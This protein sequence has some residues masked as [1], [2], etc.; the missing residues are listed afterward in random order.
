M[1]WQIDLSGKYGIVTG[2]GSGIGKATA[3]HLSSMGA[4]VALVDIVAGGLDATA[5][6]IQSAGEASPLLI[7]ADAAD[8]NQV[9]R[10]VAQCLAEFGAIDFLVNGHGILRRTPFLEIQNSEWDLMIGVNLRGCFLFCKTVLPHM[11]AR[12]QGV[13]VNVASLAGRSCSILGGAHYTAA[14]HGLIGLSRHLAREFAPHGIRVNAFC[15]GATL[16]PMIVNSTPPEEIDRV[17]ANI[18]RG[19]WAAPEEQACVIGFVLSDAAANITGA[20][21]DSNGGTLMI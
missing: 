4:R 1:A 2:A 15:P 8:E 16:T 14:K 18:P 6:E 11:K 5:R 12:G 19:R 20:C 21:I 3:L 13:I 10:S 7:Q 9:E 17:A